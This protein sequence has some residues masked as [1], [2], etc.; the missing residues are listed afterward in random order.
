[1]NS[2]RTV[3]LA[4]G[5]ALVLAMAMTAGCR[6]VPID[7]VESPFGGGSVSRTSDTVELDGASS[8]TADIEMGAGVLTIGGSAVDG[9]AMEATYDYNRP[10][11]EP[12]MEYRVTSDEGRLSLSQGDIDIPDMGG[13]VRNEWDIE[14]PGSV[15]LDVDVEMGAGE[16]R[17]DLRDTLLRSLKVALGAGEST[18]DLSG[19]WADDVDV[20]VT[21][22]VGELE[23]RVPDGIGVRIWGS[24]EG[25]GEYT[26]D[27]AFRRDGGYL[28]NDAWEDAATRMDVRIQRGVGEVRVTV[29]P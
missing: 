21:A 1:M 16:S 7:S 25:I 5:V 27:P 11:W 6:R 14:L 26:V 29:A 8:V 9:N 19:E 13:R 22:G 17:I 18:I 2:Q 28:V 20:D 23:L 10:A 24:D 12:R 3:R 15:P 4:L